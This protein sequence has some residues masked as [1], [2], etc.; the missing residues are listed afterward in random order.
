[1]HDATRPECKTA[2]QQQTE[3]IKLD[4]GTAVRRNVVLSSKA[5]TAPKCPK[6]KGGQYVNGSKRPDRAELVDEEAGGSND[7]HC[8]DPYIADASMHNCAFG[9]RKL[10][11][12]GYNGKDGQNG[13]G[14][15]RLCS[16]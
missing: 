13:M 9:Q 6:N 1:M 3:H 16:R 2:C 7:K 15:D 4:H 10:Q 14:R 8:A 11:A 5:N 12:T